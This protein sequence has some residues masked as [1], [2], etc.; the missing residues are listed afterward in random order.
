MRDA[1]GQPADA[2]HP[3]REQQLCFEAA[4]LGDVLADD[5]DARRWRIGLD[6]ARGVPQ[7]GSIRPVGRR[8]VRLPVADRLA[9]PGALQVSRDVFAVAGWN[10]SRNEVLTD[11]GVARNAV[12]RLGRAVELH[13]AVVGIQDHDDAAGQ[14]DNGTVSILA[15]PQ[16]ELRA[17]AGGDVNRNPAD[18]PRP[19]DRVSRLGRFERLAGVD[20]SSI[21]GTK[22]GS[23]ID[24]PQLIVGPPHQRLERPAELR[25]PRL[26][27]IDVAT[28]GGFH[29]SD[30]GRKPH[31][32]L[33]AR[34]GG[35]MLGLGASTL[36]HDRG[37]D[38]RRDRDDVHEA[39]QQ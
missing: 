16:G 14:L 39:G 24:R 21:A 18:Q 13:D 36:L 31:E 35:A 9:L 5:Q 15:G 8:H 10:A 33:E 25:G 26:V 34:L 32:G 23:R 20:H 3:L 6:Q 19:V 7:K 22:A 29:E 1:T 11:G 37:E 4:Q 38:D 2:F 12:E 30:G 28:I 17:Q 27:P